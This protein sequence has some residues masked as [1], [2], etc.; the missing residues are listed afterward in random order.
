M[1]SKLTMYFCRNYIVKPYLIKKGGFG[2]QQYSL[3]EQDLNV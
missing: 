2:A 1:L 3:I